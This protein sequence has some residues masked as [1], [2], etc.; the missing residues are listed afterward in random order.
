MQM[1]VERTMSRKPIR[2]GGIF[3]NSVSLSEYS[4]DTLQ[5]AEEDRR[6]GT[7]ENLHK[8]Q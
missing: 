5:P 7:V 3:P 6:E 1:E 4:T 2:S 8:S